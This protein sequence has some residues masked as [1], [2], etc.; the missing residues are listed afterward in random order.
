MI[1]GALGI[2][3]AAVA[4]EA[5]REDVVG[6]VTAALFAGGIVGDL[7][8]APR[9]PD[10]PVARRLRARVPMLLLATALVPL[11]PGVV[12][13]SVAIALTGAVLANA[14]VTLLLDLAARASARVRAEGFGWSGATLR[15][16]NAAGAG[17]AGV[18]AEQ[19]GRARRVGGRAGRRGTGDRGGVRPSSSAG[20]IERVDRKARDSAEQR[21][22][23]RGKPGRP[24]RCGR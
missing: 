6:V 22:V 15:L 9:R 11:A 8:L 24:P 5:G 13:V 3:A 1:Y 19:V 10:V 23:A 12:G 14:S 17:A 21:V 2:G 4:L 7:V 18:L 16:G 20:V